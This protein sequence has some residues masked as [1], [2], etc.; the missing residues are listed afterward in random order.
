MILNKSS[1]ERGMCHG[2]IYQVASSIFTVLICKVEFSRYMD[3]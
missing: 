2:Q 3:L 1:V